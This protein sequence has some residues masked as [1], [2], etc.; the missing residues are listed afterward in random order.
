ML[1]LDPLVN[2]TDGTPEDAYR[3]VIPECE[4]IRIATGYFN[5]TNTFHAL[6][7]S[8]GVLAPCAP[9]QSVTPLLMLRDMIMMIQADSAYLC[10]QAEVKR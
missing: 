4:E 2:N 3:E 5:L 7:P 10:L 8:T 1:R 6:V 9:N